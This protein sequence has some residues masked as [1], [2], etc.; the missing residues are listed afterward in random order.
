MLLGKC[1]LWLNKY[2]I[3]IIKTSINLKLISL[4][5]LSKRA[6]GRKGFGI[7]TTSSEVSKE[8]LVSRGDAYA[9]KYEDMSLLTL[10]SLNRV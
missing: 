9:I 1:I 3:L 2:A 7:T 10:K 8:V 5:K 6:R 4:L